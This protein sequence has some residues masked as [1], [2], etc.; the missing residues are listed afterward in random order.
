VH[1]PH[2]TRSGGRRSHRLRARW[3]SDTGRYRGSLPRPTCRRVRAD[4]PPWR[5]GASSSALYPWRSREVLQAR[6][7]RSWRSRH[8]L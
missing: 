1:R 5:L 7:L 3:W 4:R 2:S 8:R 6:A